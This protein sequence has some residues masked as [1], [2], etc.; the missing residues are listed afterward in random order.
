MNK[1]FLSDLVRKLG[2]YHIRKGTEYCFKCHKCRDT[3]HRLEINFKIG[4]NCFHCGWQGSINGLFGELNIMGD[5]EHRDPYRIWPPIESKEIEMPNGFNAL[6]I[7]M[8]PGFIAE[9][10]A[11]RNFSVGIGLTNG[12]GWCKDNF[13]MQERIIIPIK[14]DGKLVCWLARAVRDEQKPKELCPDEAVSNRS[15]FVYG[16]DDIQE[17]D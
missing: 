3:R 1:K 5:N 14:E 12:W 17:G 11:K 2:K 10:L 16:L 8:T 4:F 13:Q 7:L 6:S 15:Y 9:F